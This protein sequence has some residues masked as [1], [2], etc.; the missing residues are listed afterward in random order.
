[1]NREDKQAIVADLSGKFA[2]AK[3][4]VVSDYRGLTVSTLEQL[5]RELKKNNAEIRV[6]KNTLLRRAVQ[7]TP[8]E[9]MQE[10]LTGTTAV[11]VSYDDPVA[12]AKILTDFAKDHPQLE[13]KTAVLEGKT[14]SFD[15]LKALSSLP[16][17]EVLLAQVMSVMLAVPTSFVRVINAVPQGFVN[18]L[19]ALQEKKE[20]ENN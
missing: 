2:K 20:K 9:G 15:D 1:M 16:S 11:T 3:I 13:I 17:K 18:V 12:P 6:A 5:R 7:D 4:A 8:F 10:H 19:Q 14:L